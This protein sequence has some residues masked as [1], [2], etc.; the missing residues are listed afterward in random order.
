MIIE[1][2]GRTPDEVR[3]VI[4]Y[5]QA[6]GFCSSNILSGSKLRKQFPT[7]LAQMKNGK[8][9]GEADSESDRLL[10]LAAKTERELAE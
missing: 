3:A 7:L 6:D 2:D 8:R 5:S 9:K 1:R 4:D 10:K